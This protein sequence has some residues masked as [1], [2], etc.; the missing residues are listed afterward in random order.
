MYFTLHFINIYIYIYIP[1]PVHLSLS[2]QK[3]KRER[4]QE[5]DVGSHNNIIPILL[6]PNSNYTQKYKYLREKP[7]LLKEKKNYETNSES[8]SLLSNQ[9]QY[10]LFVSL[11][12]KKKI[13][14][15]FLYSHIHYLCVFSKVVTLCSLLLNYL[16]EG[17]KTLLSHFWQSS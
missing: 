10:L 8:I 16:L 5:S 6:I 1:L 7:F 9:L 4:R 2:L 17:D 12:K 3:K 13:L 11:L 15:I 14:L